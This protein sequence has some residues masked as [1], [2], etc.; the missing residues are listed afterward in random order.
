MEPDI[1][2][3]LLQYCFVEVRTFRPITDDVQLERSKLQEIGC[4]LQS[5]S[6]PL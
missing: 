3:V 2:K 1:G 5:M 4:R 6:T